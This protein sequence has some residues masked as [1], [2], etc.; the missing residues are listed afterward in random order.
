MKEFHHA[1]VLALVTILAALASSCAQHQHTDEGVAAKELYRDE[2]V[3]LT[4]LEIQ[5]RKT[6]S[7]HTHPGD[8]VGYV[9]EGSVMLKTGD[10]TCTPVKEDETF[11]VP[12]ETTMTVTNNTDKVTTL[13]SLI[14]G[15]HGKEPLHRVA[16]EICGNRQDAK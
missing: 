10:G 5:P 12:A 15:L 6:V 13:Y 8:E 1:S 16:G 14:A 3:R 9:A 7:P 4:K 2:Y 11:T